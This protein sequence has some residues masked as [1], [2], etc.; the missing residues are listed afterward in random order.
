M[1]RNEAIEKYRHELLGLSVDLMLMGLG[2]PGEKDSGIGLAQRIDATQQAVSRI[3]GE[4]FDAARPV[5]APPKEA[6][7]G[8]PKYGAPVHTMQGRPV[9][10]QG[11]PAG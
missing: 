11:S 9:I 10:G 2:R 6:S 7:N 5:T 8:T 4:V 3:I 1:T